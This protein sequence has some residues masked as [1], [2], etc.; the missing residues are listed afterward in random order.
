MT[1]ADANLQPTDVR[2]T[3]HN[4]ADGY[5]GLLHP[6]IWTPVGYLYRHRG[7]DL[8]TKQ[9]SY[10]IA[11]FGS[12]DPS[13]I[14]LVPNLTYDEPQP[15]YPLDK[16]GDVGLADQFYAMATET[17]APDRLKYRVQKSSWTGISRR[18]RNL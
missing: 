3:L 13:L 5:T 7:Y 16:T 1:A 17:G 9:R 8:A 6:P 11:Q 2:Q 18:R 14:V 15:T 10:Q 4:A 12:W